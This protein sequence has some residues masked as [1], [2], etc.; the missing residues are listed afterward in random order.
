[1]AIRRAQR[2]TQREREKIQQGDSALVAAIKKEASAG[3][4]DNVKVMALDLIR[5]R[6]NVARCIRLESQLGGLESSISTMTTIQNMTDALK[7]VTAAMRQANGLMKMRDFEKIVQEFER[8]AFK[9]D[10][11]SKQVDESLAAQSGKDGD[12]EE[13]ETNELVSKVLDE[14]GIDVQSALN[15][16]SAAASSAPNPLAEHKARL[17][18]VKALKDPSV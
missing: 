16:S 4:M 2:G 18:R 10:L 8:Q 7:S 14:I 15:A 6:A 5:K 17:E 11:I 1:M 12:E 3:N 9:T 13:E